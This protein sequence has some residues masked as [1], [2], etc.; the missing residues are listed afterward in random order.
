MRYKLATRVHLHQQGF[1][2]HRVIHTTIDL[3]SV[4]KQAEVASEDQRNALVLLLDFAKAYDSL[5]REFLYATLRRHVYPP[6]LV[7]V[8]KML[9]TGTT[10]KFLANGEKSR[11]LKITREIR[12]GCPLAPLLFILVLKPRYQKLY[13]PN[14]LEE[15]RI[16]SVTFQIYL[17]V[18]GYADDTENY[19]H[20][21][22]DIHS[23]LEIR[24]SI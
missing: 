13:D 24:L 2:P 3:I 23:G 22:A 1:V 6:H 18:A 21:P 7:N 11:R 5:D 14:G 19:L 17:R 9:H 8:I 15:I 16:K 4:A 20:N 10:A 12:Q